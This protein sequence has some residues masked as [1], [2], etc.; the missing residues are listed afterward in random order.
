MVRSLR[1]L[2]RRRP[3]SPCRR[4][5]YFPPAE[6]GAPGLLTLDNWVAGRNRIWDLAFPPGWIPPLYTEND[7]G[8]FFARMSGSEPARVLGSGD[9]VRRRLRPHRR[10]RPDGHR[11]S[12]GFNGTSDRRAFVCYSTTTDN[13][14][15]R[16]DVD[17]SGPSRAHQLDRDRHRAP[18]RLFHNGCRVRFQPGTGRCS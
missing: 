13:R 14:V 10:G 8:A 15:A 3:A 5:V 9:A 11:V 7:S 18:P 16:F 12:P 17:Y 1:L 6:S 4:G 2:L